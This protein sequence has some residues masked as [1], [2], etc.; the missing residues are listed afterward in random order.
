MDATSHVIQHTGFLSCDL[1]LLVAL[2]GE[3]SYALLHL[4]AIKNILEAVQLLCAHKAD[5]NIQG[6]EGDIPLHQAISYDQ[7]LDLETAMG[8]Y[9]T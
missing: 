8:G 4:A 9:A 7:S 2:V 3:K 6:G 1:Y 5:P